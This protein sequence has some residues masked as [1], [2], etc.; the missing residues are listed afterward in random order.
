M[1]PE[2]YPDIKPG[3]A[4]LEPIYRLADRAGRAGHRRLPDLL[5]LARRAAGSGA[6]RPI[7]P[8][9]I[10]DQMISSACGRRPTIVIISAC[11]SGVFVPALADANR[12]IL[13]A[14]RPDRSSFGCSESDK[15]P[16]FDAC[17]LKVLPSAHDFVGAGPGGAD[18]RRR[19][20]DRDRHAPALR[21][22]VLRRPGA[23]ADPAADG[24]EARPAPVR[25]SAAPLPVSLFQVRRQHVFDPLHECA[26]LSR[27]IAPMGD[28]ERHVERPATKIGYDL[29]KRSTLQVSANPQERRLNQ[30]KAGEGSSFVGLRA[31]DV[32]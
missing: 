23:A 32:K 9:Q 14:A 17:M 18:L 26:D 31:V 5:L 24:A 27:Q 11:F 12:M 21:A 13:T 10:M 8:P 6:G 19:Q 15:Y 29:H 25:L 4:D 2:L 28:D 30:A 1:R 3:K 22:A 16:Y 20:G 7:L